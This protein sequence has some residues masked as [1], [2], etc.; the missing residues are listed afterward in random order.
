MRRFIRYCLLFIVPC[1]L[2]LTV[3]D[4]LFSRVAKHSGN[5]SIESW[6]EILD[7]GIDADVLV[8]G[9]SRVTEH[10]N[11]LVLDS[12]LTANTYVLGMDGRAIYSQIKKYHVYREF[13][14]KPKL[15]IQNV[16][17]FSMIKRLGVNKAQFFP[18]FWNESIRNTFFPE[19]PFTVWEKYLPMY[20]YLNINYRSDMPGIRAFLPDGNK[21]LTKGYRGLNKPWDGSALAAVDSIPFLVDSACVQA[22]KDYLTEVKADGI[23]GVSGDFRIQARVLCEEEVVVQRRIQAEPFY[24]ELAGEGFGQGVTQLDLTDAEVRTVEHKCI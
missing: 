23:H 10:V 14:T 6:N 7:G 2:L 19:E 13:N 16:D 12:I 5:Q 21:K 18:F 15:I 24:E 11:P 20:R 9:S 3:A 4:F 8:V 1:Y 17:V 22:F